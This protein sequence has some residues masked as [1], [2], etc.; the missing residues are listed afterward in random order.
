MKP[1]LK[2]AAW[3]LTVLF[4]LCSLTSCEEDDYEMMDILV[5]EWRIVEVDSYDYP[6]Y[7]YGDILGF[8]PDGLFYSSRGEQGEWYIRHGIL[9]IDFTGDGISDVE[10]TIAQMDNGYVVLDVIDYYYDTHYSLRMVR[11]W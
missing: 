11:Y 3:L 6:P 9:K 8:E 5:G 1:I 4:A 2:N 10:A 7:T